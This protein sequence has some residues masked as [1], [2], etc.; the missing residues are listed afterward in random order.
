MLE[1]NLSALCLCI[2]CCC[3]SVCSGAG[4]LPI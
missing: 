3:A 1:Q 2:C 4:R